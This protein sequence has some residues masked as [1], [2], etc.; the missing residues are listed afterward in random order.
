MWPEKIGYLVKHDFSK[1][2]EIIVA[3]VIVRIQSQV[4]LCVR[5]TYELEVERETHGQRHDW[6][7]EG[8]RTR[9]M[10]CGAPFEITA[11]GKCKFCR[12][13]MSLK[14]GWVI[15]GKKLMGVADN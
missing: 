14:T 8:W 5:L 13:N 4:A 12:G 1:E 9:C 7:G 10:T 3:R 2:K 15:V 6:T 11:D